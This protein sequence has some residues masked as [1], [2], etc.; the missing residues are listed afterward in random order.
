M[1]DVGDIVRYKNIT[2]KVIFDCEYSISILIS[3]ELPKE[4]QTR[5]VVYNYDWHKVKMISDTK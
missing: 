4:T 5:V 2:G 1:F 3:D